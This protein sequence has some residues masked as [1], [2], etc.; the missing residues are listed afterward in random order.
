MRGGVAA[1]TGVEGWEREVHVGVSSSSV[2][3][4]FATV[5][6]SSEVSRVCWRDLGTSMPRSYWCL[7]VGDGSSE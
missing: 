1:W 7:W 3:E 2:S 5:T 6:V 4:K